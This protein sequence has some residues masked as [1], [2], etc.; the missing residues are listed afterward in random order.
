RPQGEWQGVIRQMVAAGLL[1][2]DIAGY[3]GLRVAADG[4]ALMRGQ[5]SFRYRP[6]RL[7]KEPKGRRS[8]SAAAKAAD[9]LDAAGGELLQHLKALRLTLAKARGVPAYVIFSDRTLADMAAKR[10]RNADEF[11]EVFGVG[12]AKRRDFGTLFLQV[13]GD[14]SR[15]A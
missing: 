8:T 3:G 15:S 14:D 4:A 11:A 5:G 7:R 2:I 10:P 1:D 6:D 9:N 13:I 12:E